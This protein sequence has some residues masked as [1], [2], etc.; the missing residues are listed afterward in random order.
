[1]YGKVVQYEVIPVLWTRV[2]NLLT[3]DLTCNLT[4]TLSSMTCDFSWS[5]K[6]LIHFQNQRWKMIHL[7]YAVNQLFFSPTIKTVKLKCSI[8]LCYRHEQQK[9]FFI[10]FGHLPEFNCRYVQQVFID[11][12]TYIKKSG[13]PCL[14]Y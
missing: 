10:F 11:Y 14:L 1:M 2:T 7:K 8:K 6:N 13:R 4:L 3:F 5:M 12:H 9:Q